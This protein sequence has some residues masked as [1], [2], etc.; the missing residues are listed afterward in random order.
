[1]CKKKLRIDLFV[2]LFICLFCIELMFG[3]KK[4]EDKKPTE[5]FHQ[6]TYI[7]DGGVNN[8][9]NKDEYIEGEKTTL[10]EATKEGHT[11]K[12]WEK[13]GKIVTEISEN[14]TSD[15]TLTAKWEKV[16]VTHKITF[17]LSDIVHL[18]QTTIEYIEGEGLEELPTPIVDERST[19][20]DANFR[21]IYWYMENGEE[22]EVVTSICKDET[23]DFVLKP[24]LQLNYVYD[25]A[26][27]KY[28]FDIEDKK[29]YP[30]IHSNHQGQSIGFRIY[31]LIERVDK[32]KIEEVT[33][34]DKTYY[35]V[36]CIIKDIYDINKLEEF[37][38]V[39][40]LYSGN[41]NEDGTPADKYFIYISK[42]IYSIYEEYDEFIVPVT[43]RYSYNFYKIYNYSLNQ[44]SVFFPD[45]DKPLSILNL[46]FINEKKANIDF[47][48]V[49]YGNVILSGQN[50][51]YQDDVEIVAHIETSY[52]KY[53]YDN[54]SLTPTL[55]EFSVWL[56][57]A[58]YRLEQRCRYLDGR[59]V[60][61]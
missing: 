61:H 44:I 33:V 35:K 18:E 5:V 29:I 1:M 39:E 36:N 47:Y 48:P 23:R 30:Y 49:V 2:L 21:F 27:E 31:A 51:F 38:N 53:V 54:L 25:V 46:E 41:C 59:G 28:R 13:D 14:E 26:F 32:M 22:T 20:Y 17:I 8:T 11:F 9:Q 57:K 50:E 19:D 42:D 37:K 55:E 3:C 43:I 52:K 4:D 12:G 45:V 10:Y 24:M 56:I 34:N 60:N 15:I 58:L 16:E 7:L 40:R 6:I